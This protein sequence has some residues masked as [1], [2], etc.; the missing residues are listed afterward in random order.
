MSTTT[1]TS[2]LEAL[3][4]EIDRTDAQL[5]EL[6]DRRMSI[7]REIAEQKRTDDVP[8][9]AQDRLDGV[10]A[11]AQAYAREHG[12]DVDFVNDV[13][14]AITLE[15]CRLEAGI[16]G[17]TPTAA[18]AGRALRIDHVAIA[19]RDL[20]QAIAL[21]RDVYGFT[22]I[23]RRAVQGEISG[24]DSATLRAGNATFVL[25][26]GDNPASNVSRYIEH[27]GP[28][29]Q[30]I[31]LSVRGQGDLLEELRGRGADLL[32]GV[33][34]SPGLDQSFTKREPNA[35][36]QLEFVTRTGNKGFSD[37]NVRELFAAMEREDVF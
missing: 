19:V 13:Y 18:L 29:V 30:H 27:Y 12:L 14:D 8:M 37:D 6:L 10:F 20:E 21:F 28:G 34:H 15:S 4:A 24:M 26:Q 16:I 5:L 33:I 32:T 7:C 11:K 36:T 22:V 3:R 9:M 35:G 1:E 17:D 2:R 23:E 31:A 25:C